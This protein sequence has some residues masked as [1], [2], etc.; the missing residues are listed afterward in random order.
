MRVYL[1]L[2]LLSVVVGATTINAAPIEPNVD[3]KSRAALTTHARVAVRVYNGLADFSDEDERT[4]LDV[5]KRVFSAALVDVAWTDCKPGMCLTL[6]PDA[7]K[8]RIIVSRQP[9]KQQSVVLGNAL[10]DS[11]ASAGVL[12]TVFIDRVERM[13]RTV[14]I[15]YRVLLGR[16]IAHE[17]GHLL[18]GT[19]KHGSGLMREVWSPDELLGTRSN[20]W[21]FDPLDAAVIRDHLARRGLSQSRGTS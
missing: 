15:D 1:S 18:L 19:S 13:A 7:L 12:A 11:H 9:G 2:V 6:E 14:G 16:A 5:A 8:I 4:S 20:D 17:L 3:D 21:A 10:V